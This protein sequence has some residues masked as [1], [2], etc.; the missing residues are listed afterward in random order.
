MMTADYAKVLEWPPRQL[1]GIA[2][3]WPTSATRSALA[4]DG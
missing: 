1:H 2:L 4:A 3:A